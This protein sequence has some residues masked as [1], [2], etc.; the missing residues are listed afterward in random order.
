MF[1]LSGCLVGSGVSWSEGQRVSD[2]PER[3][4]CLKTRGRG[5]LC[6]ALCVVVSS[7]V[8]MVEGRSGEEDE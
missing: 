6:L 8:E 7:Y 4:R 1:R 5:D 2:R 3:C